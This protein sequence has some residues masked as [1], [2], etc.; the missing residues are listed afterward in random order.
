[1][2]W[3]SLWLG[4]SGHKRCWL[5]TSLGFSE[6]DLTLETV[7]LMTLYMSVRPWARTYVHSVHTHVSYVGMPISVL[8]EDAGGSVCPGTGACR[9]R[10]AAYL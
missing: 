3:G 1:M 4:P 5:Q 9:W 2:G 6:T 10:E 8:A 7:P